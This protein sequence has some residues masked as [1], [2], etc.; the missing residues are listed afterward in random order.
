MVNVN[1]KGIDF[2][3]EWETDQGYDDVE[4]I[5]LTCVKVNGVNISEVIDPKWWQKIE[6]ELEKKLKKDKEELKYEHLI[7]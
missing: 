6:D 2:E 1:V 5:D 4:Y 7:P 3:C